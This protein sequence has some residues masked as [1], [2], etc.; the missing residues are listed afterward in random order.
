MTQYWVILHYHRHGVSPHLVISDTKPD[1][2]KIVEDGTEDY[3][4]HLGEHIDVIPIDAEQD[5]HGAFQVGQ[6]VWWHDPDDDT[7][8]G[9]VVIDEIRD[10]EAIVRHVENDDSH[11]CLPI[12]ELMLTQYK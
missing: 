9:W 10:D 12:S 6:C 11:S 3:E 8:S 7:C 2:E 4:P 5:V 1:G